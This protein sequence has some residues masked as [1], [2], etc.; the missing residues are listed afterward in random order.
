MKSCLPR[1]D[2]PFPCS[3]GSESYRPNEHDE[4]RK[5]VCFPTLQACCAR[6]REIAFERTQQSREIML[7]RNSRNVWYHPTTLDHRFPVPDLGEVSFS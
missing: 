5:N 1:T 4:A 7:R 2:T 6:A 3:V